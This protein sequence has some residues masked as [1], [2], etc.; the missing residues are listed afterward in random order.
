[1]DID[2]AIEKGVAQ[3][4]EVVVGTSTLGAGLPFTGVV[5]HH[6]RNYYE[7]GGDEN[8]AVL[9]RKSQQTRDAATEALR[10]APPFGGFFSHG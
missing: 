5:V 10:A 6:K 9:V 2:V 4:Y 8:R 1:M 3:D 7:G